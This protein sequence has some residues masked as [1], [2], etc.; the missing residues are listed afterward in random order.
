MFDRRYKRQIEDLKRDLAGEKAFSRTQMA[1]NIKLR[2]D[3]MELYERLEAIT[4]DRDA[5]KDIAHS[6]DRARREML[7]RVDTHNGY[8]NTKEEA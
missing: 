3:N 5:W 7:R 4:K 2:A 1:V 8:N 6:V